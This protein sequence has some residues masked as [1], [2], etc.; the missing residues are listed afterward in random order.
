M[1]VMMF[2]EVITFH[3]N[4]VHNLKTSVHP[5]KTLIHPQALDGKPVSECIIDSSVM[6]YDAQASAIYSVMH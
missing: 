6:H 1:W 3:F 5:I 2:T 4:S